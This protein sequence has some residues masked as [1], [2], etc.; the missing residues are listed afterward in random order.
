MPVEKP[1][2]ISAVNVLWIEHDDPRSAPP[3]ELLLTLAS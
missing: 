1:C 3:Q 2:P